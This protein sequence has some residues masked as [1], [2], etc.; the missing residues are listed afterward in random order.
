MSHRH[1]DAENPDGLTIGAALAALAG[2]LATAGIDSARL[3]ARLLL[4]HAVGRDPLWIVAHPELALDAAARER[5]AALAERRERRQPIAQII[6][7]REFWSL[8]F[9]VTADTLCPRP[10]TETLVEAV[11][12]SVSDRSAPLR[13]LDLG[14]GTGCLLLSL[15]S[16]LPN[17]RGVGVDCSAAALAVARGNADILNL[18]PRAEF[19]S[20]DW[21]RGLDGLFDVIVSNPPYIAENDIAELEPEVAAHEPRGALAGGID[22]LDCYRRM[23]ADVVRLLAPR[24]IAAVEVGVGQAEAV[25][26]I[27]T[28][29]GANG[30]AVRRDLSGVDRCVIFGDWEKTS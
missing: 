26:A 17:A 5:L 16:E 23:A 15:L 6:G 19:V 22:G 21:G 27:F 25:C 7:E 12:A 18:A 4:A 8:P 13:L 30:T 29:A 28:R 20:G 14:T 11:L 10:E 9:R 2:R 24:G 3:D 1:S